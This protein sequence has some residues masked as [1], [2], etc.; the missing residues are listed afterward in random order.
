L[1]T[2]IGKPIP[3][4]EVA[5]PNVAGACIKP[6]RQAALL[7][8]LAQ[9]LG[10]P[11][12]SGMVRTP[13]PRPK[14][15]AKAPTHKERILL[16]ED[17]VVNQEVALGNLRKLGY[18]ADVAVNGLEV[19]Y[20]LESRQY[21]IILMDCQMPE[22]DGYETTRQIRHRENGGHHTRIIAMTANAMVG[23]RDK[24]L[25]AGMDD[26]LSKPL[27]RAELRAALERNS[28]QPASPLS[29]Q[30]LLGIVEDD[31][32]ELATLVD[33][34]I[35]TAPESITQMRA[36]LDA[37]DANRLAMAAHTLKGSSA[38]LGA[39]TLREVCAQIEKNGR[40]AN[41]N[42]AADLVASAAEELHRFCDALH[43]FAHPKAAV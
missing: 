3:S 6:V 18:D 32:Q 38:S 21:D 43:A 12:G 14:A 15:N 23:D 36:A 24:C 40:E 20:A 37:L 34:F 39:T 31:P 25:A 1:L 42:G 26:Y 2:P 29:E 41:L 9:V 16:A 30:I 4:G 7:D 17:N 5:P 11:A 13:E 19:L 35:A 33:L 10:Q 22:I 8:C 27:R 28:P